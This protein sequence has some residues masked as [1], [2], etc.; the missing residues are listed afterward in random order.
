MLSSRL[1]PPRLAA[2]VP[3][4][5]L[6]LACQTNGPGN[7]SVDARPDRDFEPAALRQALDGIYQGK[8][9]AEAPGAPGAAAATGIPPAA[10]EREP[11]R[12]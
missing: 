12:Q 11:V 6:T 10:G 2:L 9:L 1:A 7:R 8:I 4:V 5:T 3:L